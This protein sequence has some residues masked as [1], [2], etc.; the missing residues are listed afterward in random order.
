MG[1][2]R[3]AFPLWLAQ[4]IRQA[5]DGACL[6]SSAACDGREH[7]FAAMG[8][9]LM[10][11]GNETEIV[12]VTTGQKYLIKVTVVNEKEAEKMFSLHKPATI[13]GA[14]QPK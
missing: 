9:Q 5:L 7:H 12:D 10:I 1:K 4:Q 2:T 3:P 8:T 11:D 14:G 6:V 13:V